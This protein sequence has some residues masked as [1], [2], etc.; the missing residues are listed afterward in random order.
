MQILVNG[1]QLHNGDALRTHIERNSAAVY[2]RT[3]APSRVRQTA[4][5]RTGYN[6]GTAMMDRNDGPVGG[7]MFNLLREISASDSAPDTDRMR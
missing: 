6:D 5:T 1:R 7:N 2:G 3:P 4:L